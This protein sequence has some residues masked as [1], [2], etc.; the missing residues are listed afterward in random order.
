M[1]GRSGAGKTT[2]MS[3]LY[4]V[5]GANRVDGFKIIPKANDFKE[6]MAK[7]GNFEQLSFESRD[8][9]FPPGTNQTVGWSFD[10]LY[11]NV[12]VCSFDWIDYR[13]SILDQMFIDGDNEGVDELIGHVAMSN[14]V[15]VFAD[16]ISLTHFE[17]AS[18]RRK[19]SGAERINQIFSHYSTKYLGRNLS[20][21]ILLTKADSDLIDNR[22]KE[23]NYAPLIQRGCE[24][25]S[26]II[27]LC[28]YSNQNWRGGIVPVGSVGEGNVK[29]VIT[30]QKDFKSPLVVNTEI[31]KQPSPLN[32]EHPLFF[33]IGEV[34]HFMEAT[35]Y[36][37]RQVF[38]MHYRYELER[39][40]LL[41]EFWSKFT[42]TMGP[43]D[44]ARDFANKRDEED[45]IIRSMSSHMQPLIQ[46]AR[47]KVK[48]I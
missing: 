30:P 20:I 33:S 7:F 10:F 31:I 13:G 21:V 18:E 15:M 24:A 9:Q 36:V 44:M 48:S 28:K 22:W 43:Q 2:Y 14:A 5:L 42:N 38:E 32:V 37:N 41:R 34:L 17:N 1:I 8:Y 35:A 29:S 39:S 26:E 16:S 45:R 27:N 11:K 12:P 40:N 19:K 46:L 23:N 4:E 47:K 3:A 6:S 25:F